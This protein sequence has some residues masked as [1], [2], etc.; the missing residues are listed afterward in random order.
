MNYWEK[1][2][3]EKIKLENEKN[4]VKIMD[5][6]VDSLNVGKDFMITHLFTPKIQQ[7]LGMAELVCSTKILYPLRSEMTC[8]L[9]IR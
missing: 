5:L 6:A 7:M 3:R 9:K 8:R 2:L 1:I 4:E